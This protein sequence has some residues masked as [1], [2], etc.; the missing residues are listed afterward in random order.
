LLD[1]HFERFS[2]N[3]NSVQAVDHLLLRKGASD[4]V[5][6]F[7]DND[8]DTSGAFTFS[9]GQYSFTHKALGAD[10]FRYSWNFGKNWTDWHDW[11]DTTFINQSTFQGSDL[12]WTGNHI[13]VQCQSSSSFSSF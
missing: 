8:Y 12:F 3:P 11:E 10:Q 6:V 1:C 5:L 9:D 2:S 7:P 13:M 4:N